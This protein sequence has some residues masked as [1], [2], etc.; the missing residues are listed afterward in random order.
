MFV[1]REYYLD[2]LASLW[3]KSTSSLVACRGRRRVGKSRLF[4]EFALRTADK[5]VELVGLPPR[6]GMTNQMQLDAFAA[7]LARAFGGAKSR[8][9]DWSEAFAAL[10]RCIESRKRT[11]VMCL[12]RS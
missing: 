10:D 3:R 8:F 6:K 11:V 4:K 1:G 2:D 9:E 7:G 12:S 5:Y